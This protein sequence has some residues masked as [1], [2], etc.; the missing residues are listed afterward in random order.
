MRFHFYEKLVKCFTKDSIHH[1]SFLKEFFKIQTITAESIQ[2]YY[3]ESQSDEILQY[4][5]INASVLNEI[6][7]KNVKEIRLIK[8]LKLENLVYIDIQLNQINKILSLVLFIL[9][10]CNISS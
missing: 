4:V 6:Y 9:L 5:H 8:F 10:Y 3:A 1:L 7:T 2:E